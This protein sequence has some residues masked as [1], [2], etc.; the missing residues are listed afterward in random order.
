L[1][2]NK[3]ADL[4]REKKIIESKVISIFLFFF[5]KLI[6]IKSKGKIGERL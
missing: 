2:K 3:I 5:L 6:N 1:L 4:T